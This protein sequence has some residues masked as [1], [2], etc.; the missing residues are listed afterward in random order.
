[1]PPEPQTHYR[2]DDRPVEVSPTTVM[3]APTGDTPALNSGNL[4]RERLLVGGVSFE[5]L[6]EACH[7]QCQQRLRKTFQ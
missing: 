3:A 1:M 6:P 2:R 4:M 5:Q 7:H